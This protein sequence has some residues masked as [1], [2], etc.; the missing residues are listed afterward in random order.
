MGQQA[1][2]RHCGRR[3]DLDDN[4]VTADGPCSYHP[5]PPAS[6]GN[7]GPRGDYAE[8]WRFPC[9]GE[10]VVGEI[11]D[12]GGDV[13]PSRSPGCRHGVHAAEGG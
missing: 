4:D 3:F 11:G 9:C 12:D 6:I 10:T 1:L 13:V 5:H 8:I 7:T 2:C